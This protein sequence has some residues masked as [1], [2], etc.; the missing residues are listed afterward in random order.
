MVAH[1]LGSLALLVDVGSTTTKAVLARVGGAGAIEVLAVEH[2]P[3]TV[4]WPHED[5]MSGVR[6]AVAMAVAATAGFSDAER[7]AARSLPDMLGS[8]QIRPIPF[9]ATSSAGGG[10]QM[11]VAGTTQI[12]SAGAAERVALGAGAVVLASLS[13]DDGRPSTEKM[14]LIRELSPDMILIAGGYDGGDVPRSTAELVDILASVRIR[15]RLG[16]TF[17]LPIVYAG[18]EAGYSLVSDVLGD[19]AIIVRVDNLMPGH[20]AENPG[21]ARAAIHELFQ[22]HVMQ[23]A[24]GFSGLTELTS[25][26]VMPTP[27]AVA[28]A[29]EL[30]NQETGRPVIVY[31]I[32]GATTDVFSVAAGVT[33]RT[34]SANLGMS[35]SA[36]NVLS[37]AGITRLMRRL[38][39]ISE[40]SIRETIASKTVRP[41]TLPETIEDLAVEQAVATEAL[42]LAT[43]DHLKIVRE[44]RLRKL[45]RGQSNRRPNQGGLLDELFEG[46]PL[47]LV[48]GSGGVLSFVP[49]EEDACAILTGALAPRRPC[50]LTVDSRFLLP[51]VGLLSTIDRAAAADML[52]RHSLRRLAACLPCRGKPGSSLAVDVRNEAG[53]QIGKWSF[54]PGERQFLC[55]GESGRLTITLRPTGGADCGFGPNRAH[56]TAVNA[57]ELGVLVSFEPVTVEAET[58]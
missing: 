47:P 42:R 41:T 5:V 22:T 52:N 56:T 43:I 57:G 44:N 8:R 45:G 16:G 14:D 51:Q 28:R 19:Q 31:D 34:V 9:Y 2:A 26:P 25:V 4:E 32:G 39:G 27:A 18:N 36:L 23:H 58:Q 17:R 15:S 1:T 29:T 53:S 30:I 21:P 38:P 37:L 20:R 50:E 12:T 3:T 40:D 35:Y 6:D 24:P 54:G 46:E 49:R 10:L 48:V 55:R 7:V 33:T 11:L 13:P